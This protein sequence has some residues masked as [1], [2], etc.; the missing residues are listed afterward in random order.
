M[1]N[2]TDTDLRETLRQ[3]LNDWDAATDEQRAEA[4]AV[5]AFNAQADAHGWTERDYPSAGAMQGH[6]GDFVEA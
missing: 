4:L 6:G 3:M 5:A 1:K 2:T